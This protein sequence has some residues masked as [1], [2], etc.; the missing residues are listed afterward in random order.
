MIKLPSYPNPRTR[1]KNLSQCMYNSIFQ[2]MDLSNLFLYEDVKDV[3]KCKLKIKEYV[4][5]QL[6][7]YRTKYGVSTYKSSFQTQWGKVTLDLYKLVNL[8]LSDKEYLEF[9]ISRSF[10]QKNGGNLT[11]KEQ[12]IEIYDNKLEAKA[13]FIKSC[14]DVDEP[15]YLANFF[16]KY[17]GEMLGKLALQIIDDE[18][19]NEK[20]VSELKEKIKQTPGLTKDKLF[21][22]SNSEELERML[23]E[24][25]DYYSYNGKLWFGS[26]EDFTNWG[27]SEYLMFIRESQIKLD[28]MNA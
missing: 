3:V 21:L 24:D 5:E 9:E 15:K 2:H 27:K 26:L 12:F 23:L 4:F 13:S 1:Y 18:K 20:L 14:E 8:R 19:K 11:T 7:E 10:I 25:K 16:D 6:T 22:D 17:Y 28:D